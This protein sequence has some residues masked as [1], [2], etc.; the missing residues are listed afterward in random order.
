[1]AAMDSSVL[2]PSCPGLYATT[3]LKADYQL[4]DHDETIYTPA[5]CNSLE[6]NVECHLSTAFVTCKTQWMVPSKLLKS[7]ANQGKNSCTFALPMDQKGVVTSISAKMKK[8]HIQSCVVPVA[9]TGKFSGEG[10][11]SV[12]LSGPA[13]AISG[14][15][16]RLDSMTNSC[17]FS[18][19]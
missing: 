18:R 8:M 9:D 3:I 5:E 19:F 14:G 1:M 10:T 7:S 2:K 15:G 4:R 17:V 13:A 6:F 16:T 12:G 11:M